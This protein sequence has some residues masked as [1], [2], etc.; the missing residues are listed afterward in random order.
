MSYPKSPNFGLS[1]LTDLA[2]FR[3]HFTRT[4]IFAPPSVRQKD[5][6]SIHEHLVR[7]AGYDF[8]LRGIRPHSRI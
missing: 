7:L 6:T 4:S 1:V 5:T 8:G 3:P 2:Q